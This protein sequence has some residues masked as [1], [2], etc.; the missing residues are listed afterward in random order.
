MKK[1]FTFIAVAITA[2]STFASSTDAINLRDEMIIMA[3]R[4]N[5]ANRA[6]SVEEFQ[7]S[8][9]KFID[10]A[11]KSKATLPPK[12]NGDTSQF[13]GYQQGLQKVIDIATQASELA[14]QNK[15]NEAKE[16][17][18]ELPELRKMYHKLYK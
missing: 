10:A 13:S 14:K 8:M 1:L 16:K 12:W 9:T 11:E 17:L 15:L 6:D 2:I 5:F 3:Q 18:N 4:L 7:N